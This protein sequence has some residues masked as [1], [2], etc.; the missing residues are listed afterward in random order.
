MREVRVIVVKF[1]E[2]LLDINEEIKVF[3]RGKEVLEKVLEYIRK[4]IVLNKDS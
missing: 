1:C 4:D 2:S 3:I